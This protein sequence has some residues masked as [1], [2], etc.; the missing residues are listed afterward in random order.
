MTSICHARDGLLW[1]LS[2]QKLKNWR[3]WRQGLKSVIKL[4]IC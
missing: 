2:A 4:W 1:Q 3:R